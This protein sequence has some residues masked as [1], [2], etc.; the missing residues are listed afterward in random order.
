MLNKQINTAISILAFC[1]SMVGAQINLNAN[2][3]TFRDLANR[4]QTTTH[5]GK[6]TLNGIANQAENVVYV[7]NDVTGQINSYA[8][9]GESAPAATYGTGGYFVGGAYGLYSTAIMSGTGGNNQRYGSYSWAANGTSTNYGA[10]N[11]AQSNGGTSYGVYAFGNGTSVNYGVFATAAGGAN[12]DHYGIWAE[13]NGSMNNY[14]V[15]GVANGGSLGSNYG[16]I[17]VANGT[18][19]TKYG[20]Y[21]IGNGAYTGSWSHVSDEKLKKDIQPIQNILEKIK[22]LQPVSY[23]YDLEKYP[24]MGLNKKKEFGITAQNLESVF[25]DMVSNDVFPG[26]SS[27][28]TSDSTITQVKTPPVT[29]KGVDYIQLIPVL[30]CAIQEQQKEIEELRALVQK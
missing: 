3:I 22:Q 25:P 10:Y 28:V 16:V 9:K 27:T 12:N 2:V 15:Y 19:A 14:G 13:A 17:G 1:V 8:I 5:Y 30:L 24:E 23:N 18:S 4:G 26:K 11:K 20:V 21:C 7:K 29:Y 6:L